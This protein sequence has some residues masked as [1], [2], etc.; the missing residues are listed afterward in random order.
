M[1]EKITIK[2]ATEVAIK[3]DIESPDE[4]TGLV[5]YEAS[6]L[7]K[8]VDEFTGK[9]S[10]G[11]DKL[12]PT[13]DE[14]S[15]LNELA[16]VEQDPDNWVILRN[17]NV[18]GDPDLVDSHGDVFAMRALKTMA[19]QAK[20]TPILTDHS[21]DLGNR[22]PVGMALSA[23]AS[24]KGL[25]ETWA[26]PKEEYNAD[27]RKGL[28]NGTVNKISIGAFISPADKVCNSC[29]KSIYSMDC[30][31]I[32]NRKDENG[33]DVTVTIKDVKRYAE[34]SLVNIPARL[35]TG[36][37]SASLEEEIEKQEV[38]DQTVDELTKENIEAEVVEKL[39]GATIS[40]VISEDSIVS[41]KQ[42][43]VKAPEAT[44]EPA[45]EQ[46]V[47]VTEAPVTEEEAKEDAA[48][49]EEVKSV[50]VPVVKSLEVEEL[51]KGLQASF[52]LEV[53][54]LNKSLTEANEKFVKLAEMQEK[55]ANDLGALT[56]SVQALTEQVTKA[57]QLSSDET[58]EKLLEIASQLKEQIEVKSA[59][60]QDMGSIVDM[61][62]TK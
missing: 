50:E 44:E 15:L 26:I 10:K 53:E 47:V 27:I 14:L 49:Q 54:A 40:P 17:V 19:L 25:L 24:S 37:K 33:K 31:H 9:A 6:V 11:V 35:N 51:T 42:E 43:D 12:Y 56:A 58:V 20:G 57:V 38:D 29:N 32:P 30:T 61:L 41:E 60:P 22:P 46:E 45:K 23:K 4:S 48:P 18:T 34:R 59:R 1:V 16:P 5:S 39:P 2:S 8:S 52:K 13:E 28:T 55:S 62:A 21:H 7:I 36:F 3:K